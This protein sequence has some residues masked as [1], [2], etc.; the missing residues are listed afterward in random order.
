MPNTMLFKGRLIKDA[1]IA[2]GWSRPDLIRKLQEFGFI[3]AER[4]LANWEEEETAPG[5]DDLAILARALSK[6][7]MAFYLRD[8]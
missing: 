6:P 2:L 1:R 5:A 7:V 8:E 3:L 4:T